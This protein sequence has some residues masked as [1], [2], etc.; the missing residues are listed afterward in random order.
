M[1][2]V[3]DICKFP[4]PSTF[5]PYFSRGVPQFSEMSAFSPQFSTGF[6]QFSSISAD[7]SFSSFS[8]RQ[9]EMEVPT[10]SSHSSN[11]SRGNSS[12]FR[13]FVA[14]KFVVFLQFLLGDDFDLEKFHIVSQIFLRR[15]SL[16]KVGIFG[17]FFFANGF[18]IL[19]SVSSQKIMFLGLGSSK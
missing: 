18:H 17:F 6:L 5:S 4:A 10:R 16:S 14:T 3:I 2:G 7:F 13:F 11:G 8:P 1:Q 12:A 9:F 19:E 15:K